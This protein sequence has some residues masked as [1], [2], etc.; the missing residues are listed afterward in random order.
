MSDSLL[1][2]FGPCGVFRDIVGIG[3]CSYASTGRMTLAIAMLLGTIILL[4][5]VFK[6]GIKGARPTT[7]WMHRAAER[8]LT[9]YPDGDLLII[10]TFICAIVLLVVLI[11]EGLNGLAVWVLIACSLVYI[12]LFVVRTGKRH[13]ETDPDRD[14]PAE[15]R[16]MSLKELREEVERR[17]LYKTILSQM[18]SQ[19]ETCLRL[20]RLFTISIKKKGSSP[21]SFP[22]SR[23]K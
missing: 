6:G 7:K 12:G 18:G 13:Q 4:Y 21:S 15:V 20:Q 14:I 1:L 10:G 5:I 19:A 2:L 9:E 17:E 23:R 3:D 11:L 22:S 16:K 8:N